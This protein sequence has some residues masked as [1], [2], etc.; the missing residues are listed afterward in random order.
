MEA[1]R[2][3]PVAA[4]F[5]AAYER[6]AQV[7]ACDT[8]GGVEYQRV[9]AEWRRAGR[10]EDVETFI[11][12]RAN[13]GATMLSPDMEATPAEELEEL[14]RICGATAEDRRAFRQVIEGAYREGWGLDRIVEEM[15]IDL[16]RAAADLEYCPCCG[17]KLGSVEEAVESIES[18]IGRLARNPP[19]E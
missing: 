11:R 9:R 13:V 14:Y 12:E 19:L 18:L 5:E 2:N 10:P 6:L 17:F 7:G 8:P 16:E 15:G 4:S 3:D 1:T